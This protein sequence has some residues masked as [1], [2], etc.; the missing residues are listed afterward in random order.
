ML[1]GS[2]VLAFFLF[3]GY[4]KGGKYGGGDM[5]GDRY[6]DDSYADADFGA[7]AGRRS[8]LVL[9]SIFL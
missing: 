7:Y 2:A 4:S 8:Q 9:K 5:Y 1:K 3:S 6:R